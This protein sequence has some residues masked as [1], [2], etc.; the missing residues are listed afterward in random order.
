MT[1]MDQRV[2]GP[3]FLLVKVAL[4]GAFPTYHPRLN[5]SV[6]WNIRATPDDKGPYNSNCQLYIYICH[7]IYMYIMIFVLSNLGYLRH[8][9]LRDVYINL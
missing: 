4:G 8:R 9:N 7:N 2:P 6:L 5:K 3:G 1:D